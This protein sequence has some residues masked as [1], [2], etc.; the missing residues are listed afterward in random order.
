MRSHGGLR[1][2]MG[3][4]GCTCPSTFCEQ[5]WSTTTPSRI[6]K[7]KEN[8]ETRNQGREAR[9]VLGAFEEA[10]SAVL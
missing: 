8:E 3:A 10:A 4:K 2:T 5:Q 9:P 7:R 1:I 6:Q